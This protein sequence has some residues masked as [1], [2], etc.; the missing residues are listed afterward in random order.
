[1]DHE[2]YLAYLRADNEILRAAAATALDKPV[3]TCPGWTGTDLL[4]HVAEVYLDKATTMRL[5]AQPESWPPDFTG[6]D[7]LVAFDAAAVDVLA[8]LTARDP[9]EQT[10]T[11][12]EP[13]QSVG[14]WG[15]RMAQEAVIHRI[16]AEAAAGVESA[17]VPTELATDGIDE[18]LITFLAFASAAYP[19]GFG[20]VLDTLDGR[21]VRVEAGASSWYVTLASTITVAPSGTADATVRADPDTLLRWLWRRAPVDA[22]TVEGDHELAATLYRLL[23]AATQ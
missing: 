9:A 12:Y 4:F 16:D 2:T 15:R 14:F 23:E 21:V 7:P 6:Q 17:P 1:M 18:V 10:L 3:P 5:N 19:S 22:V 13:D 11:W 20:G 8:E